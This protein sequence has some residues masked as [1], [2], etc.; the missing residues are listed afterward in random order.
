ML[1]SPAI[2][3][4]LALADDYAVRGVAAVES[5]CTF[6]RSW[7]RAG[8]HTGR[9]LKRPGCL[10]DIWAIAV[11]RTA[12]AGRNKNVKLALQLGA[13][14][15]C[16][17]SRHSAKPLI[18]RKHR[19]LLGRY[20]CYSSTMPCGR[21]VAI[22]PDE[23]VDKSHALCPTLRD[24]PRCYPP[25]NKEARHHWARQVEKRGS[26]GIL[27]DMRRVGEERDQSHSTGWL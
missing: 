26:S 3:V 27:E 20:L 1:Q 11:S 14:Q 15:R 24:G 7:L 16:S 6:R 17:A 2:G 4:V 25:G 9:Q 10:F 13:A 18:W 23:S 12:H 21:V 5:L 22:P 8:V 19:N